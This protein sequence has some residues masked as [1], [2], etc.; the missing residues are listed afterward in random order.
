[1]AVEGDDFFVSCCGVQVFHFLC[2]CWCSVFDV[3]VCAGDVELLSCFPNVW[4][5]CMKDVVDSVIELVE[6]CVGHAF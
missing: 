3:C 6:C 1:M 4:C 2:H 5:V